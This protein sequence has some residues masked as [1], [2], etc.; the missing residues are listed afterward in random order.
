MHGVI[1][2]L[3]VKDLFHVKKKRRL[4]FSPKL[5]WGEGMDPK[6]LDRL[7]KKLTDSPLLSD[8]VLL[9]LP[10]N[11]SDQIDLIPSKYLVQPFYAEHALKVVGIAS[12]REDAISL[13][14][15]ITEDCLAFR[16]DCSLKE[17]LEWQ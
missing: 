9:T 12:D 11:D 8:L 6:D 14:M 13:V 2:G 15:K 4:E 17:F 10:E 1:T 5:Y 16:K 7:S 3:R